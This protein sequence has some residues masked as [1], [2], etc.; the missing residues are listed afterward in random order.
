MKIAIYLLLF[1]LFVFLLL[2]RPWPFLL[3]LSLSLLSSISE[4][5]TLSGSL[6]LSLVLVSS[7]M[8]PPVTAAILVMLDLENNLSFSL[9]FRFL[10]SGPTLDFVAVR[11]LTRKQNSEVYI[12]CYDKHLPDL[13]QPRM[14]LPYWWVSSR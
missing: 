2:L 13:S 8:I 6:R 14:M 7:F 1:F 12:K 4:F 10:L 9:N 5:W 11:Y 3:S